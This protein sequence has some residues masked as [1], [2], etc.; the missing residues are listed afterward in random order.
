[1]NYTKNM[2]KFIERIC[3]WYEV[4]GEDITVEEL[5]VIWEQVGGNKKKFLKSIEEE[6]DIPLEHL[7]EIW[8]DTEASPTHSEECDT[9]SS[10]S[11]IVKKRA[12]K[13]KNTGELKKCITITFG[14]QAEN[15]K[16]MEKIGEEAEDGFTCDD[17]REIYE[18]LSEDGVDVELVNLNGP[19]EEMEIDAP[20]A[21]VLII[22]DGINLLLE[23]S[24]K[25]DLFAELTD[26]VWDS[27]ALMY[28]QVRN[29]NARHNVCFADEGQE[30]DYEAGKGRIIAWDD[31]P[32]LSKLRERMPE[33]LGEK[34]EDLV[35]EGNYYFDISKCGI[36]FHGDAER[37]KVVAAR[38]GADMPIHYQWFIK[39][40]PVGERI[41]LEL[42]DGDMYVMSEKAVGT[43]WKRSSIYTLRHATG[44]DRF[45]TIKE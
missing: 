23:D 7:E 5:Q 19:L 32:L 15:H 25:E 9:G 6:Y 14:D 36:G 40:K 43:D 44:C 41:I 2:K 35:G 29:K 38:V 13:E 21:S 18:K 39:N 45:T 30:P 20:E 26:F 10:S 37:R 24:E 17:L 11:K 4:D 16:G 31:V 8:N 1:M 42:K 22:R 3:E 12:K 28:G 34:S 33:Y 27:K